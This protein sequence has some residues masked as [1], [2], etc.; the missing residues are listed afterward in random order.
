M[1]NLDLVSE[2]R[3][4]FLINK[5]S[6]LK[7]SVGGIF[8]VLLGILSI[9]CMIG[10][11]MDLISK[12]VPTVYSADF[13]IKGD[14]SLQGS[15]F[16]GAFGPMIAGGGSLSDL[17]RMIEIVSLSCQT[18]PDNNPIT[19]YTPTKAKRC[20]ETAEL[21][22]SYEEMKKSFLATEDNYFCIPKE[23]QN[24]DL[25]NTFGNPK[26][27]TY[28]IQ[29]SYCKNTTENNNHCLPREDIQKEIEEV[30]F[31]YVFSSYSIDSSDYSEPVKFLYNNKIVRTSGYANRQD[32]FY[33]KK[34]E[35][36][37]DN[38]LILE[39]KKKYEGFLVQNHAIY[40]RH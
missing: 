26:F 10:F 23:T 18:N 9:L 20:N 6:T 32:T 13:L 33:L 8:T 29:I 7:T 27:N 19:L 3:G 36:F 14:Y 4:S 5:H 16:N 40:S 11:G 38:G 37:S 15:S 30:Y 39:D 17:D 1:E 24:V 35:Y 12:Q 25:K 22:D 21:G 28:M 34:F 31:Q 2:F